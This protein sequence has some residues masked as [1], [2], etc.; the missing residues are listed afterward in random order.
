MFGN[1]IKTLRKEN[2]MSQKDLSKIL[3]V[4]DRSI[5]YYETEERVP[6]QDIL[7]KLADFFNTSVDYILGRTNIK[8]SL[9]RELEPDL[10]E[11]FQLLSQANGKLSKNDKKLMTDLIRTFVQNK[12]SN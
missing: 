11:A 8:T 5:G 7:Q 9:V 10:C 6:P 3:G 1:R 2:N 12:K 4:T